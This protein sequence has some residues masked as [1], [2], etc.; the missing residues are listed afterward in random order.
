M[1]EYVFVYGT[2]LSGMT[3][4]GILLTKDEFIGKGVAI[5][6]LYLGAYPAYI[7]D[8]IYPVLGEVY[9]V[10]NKP[11]IIKSLDRYEGCIPKLPEASLYTREEVPITMEDESV[12]NSWIYCYNHTTAGFYLIEDGDFVRLNNSLKVHESSKALKRLEEEYIKDKN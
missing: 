8:G 6:S 9:D 12:I 4:G 5:G 11:E 7:K 10:T 3:M 1:K 2:L